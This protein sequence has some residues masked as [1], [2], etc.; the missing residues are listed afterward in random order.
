MGILLTKT[1]AIK[2]IFKQRTD[3]LGP[4][5][6]NHLLWP[7]GGRYDFLVGKFGFLVP[8]LGI[9]DKEQQIFT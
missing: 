8:K 2:A 4:Q 3:I 1:A 7:P 5:Y 9:L 6:L